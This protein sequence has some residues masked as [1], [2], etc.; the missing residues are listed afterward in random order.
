MLSPDFTYTDADHHEFLAKGFH[1]FPRFLSASGLLLAQTRASHILSNLHDSIDPEWI[2]NVH[3]QGEDWVTDI[4]TDPQVLEVV[5]AQFDACAKP[6]VREPRRAGSTK[7]CR[8]ALQQSHLF[9]KR[10]N[11]TKTVPWHQDGREG[12]PAINSAPD[13]SMLGQSAEHEEL[14]WPVATLWI[15]LD[16]VNAYNGQY[17]P[18]TTV[19]SYYLRPV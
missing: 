8:I 15:P 16:D 7:R 14:P 12:Q 4:A 18:T 1:V 6:G 11:C 10:P 5:R 9:C 17:Q 2:M 3:Q 19:K 13:S